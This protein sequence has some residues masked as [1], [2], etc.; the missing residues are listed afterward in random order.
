MEEKTVKSFT[1]V[2]SV[3]W[4]IATA[5]SVARGVYRG[6]DVAVKRLNAG[7]IVVTKALLEEL[8]Q[9]RDVNASFGER[10]SHIVVL[11][12]AN[13]PGFNCKSSLLPDSQ[14]GASKH[15]SVHR[16]LHRP[17]KYLCLLGV[18]VQRQR[19]KHNMGRRI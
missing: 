19:G 8:V 13:A 11:S 15:Q 10:L 14:H 9:V 17:A 4:A 6:T 3:N 12:I 16:S 18:C 1:T 7:N 2:V 5:S